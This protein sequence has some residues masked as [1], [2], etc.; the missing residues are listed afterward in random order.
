MRRLLVLLPCLALLGPV[1]AAGS[2]D[3]QV[4]WPAGWVVTA[5]PAPG[6]APG[7]IRER[8]NPPGDGS[9]LLIMEFTRTAQHEPDIDLRKVL[10]HMRKAVQL[11]TLR[12]GLHTAC[13]PPR[14]STFGRL[15]GL[16]TTC[17]TRRDDVDLM[18][19]TLLVALGEGAAYSLSY[20]GEAQR[21]ADSAA[22]IDQVRAS[23]DPH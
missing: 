13:T 8:A 16:E 6:Q 19:Q 2:E 14:E 5:L 21:Y 3:R 17:T 11:E 1:S 7:D 10:T 23:L 18:R 15:P 4:T 9:P 20:A 12:Q 22:L